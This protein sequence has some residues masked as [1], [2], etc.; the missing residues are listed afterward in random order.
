MCDRKKLYILNNIIQ[1]EVHM[2]DTYDIHGK[3]TDEIHVN[4]T[5]ETH[6]KDIDELYEM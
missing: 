5:Y 1:V 4:H 3:G 6:L 2:K